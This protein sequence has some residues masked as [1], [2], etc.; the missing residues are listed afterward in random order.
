MN[1]DDLGLT[2]AFSLELLGLLEE[3]VVLHS[4]DGSVYTCSTAAERVLGLSSPQA[5][6]RRGLFSSLEAVGED[7]VLLTPDVE[8]AREALRTGSPAG[9]CR[10]RIKRPN[11]EPAWLRVRAA[12]LSQSFAGRSGARPV[13]GALTVVQDLSDLVLIERRLQGNMPEDAFSRLAGSVAH[14]FNHFLTVI[15]GYNSL[16]LEKLPPTAPL[17]EYAEHVRDAASS[18]STLARELLDFSRRQWRAAGAVDL[19][20]TITGM[21]P[22]L[23]RLLGADV[24]LRLDLGHGSAWVRA[25]AGQLERVILNLAL[26]ARDAMHGGGEFR[27]ATRHVEIDEEFVHAH[28]G[29]QAGSFVRLTVADTGAGMDAVTRERVFEPF[30]TTKSPGKGTGLGL[31][32]VY[33]IVKQFGGYIEVESEPGKGAEFR[34][35]LPAQ[36]GAP[37]A[38][39]LGRMDEGAKSKQP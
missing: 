26:N 19:K 23:T 29:A 21:Q 7:G 25:D 9:P 10:L 2:S 15:T 18:A 38:E 12:P 6:G 22:M 33:G 3:G 20:R 27:L 13:V 35:D 5:N 32:T 28:P 17:R 4:R 30:F 34:I 36:G 16:M 11:G 24:R 1:A 31:A 14:D 37:R 39:T 8:P